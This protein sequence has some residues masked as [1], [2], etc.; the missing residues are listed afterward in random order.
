MV[1]FTKHFP[2]PPPNFTPEYLFCLFLMFSNHEQERRLA[3]WLKWL[4]A[5]ASGFE[6]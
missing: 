5:E 6:Q 3:D 4:V 1:N 2:P